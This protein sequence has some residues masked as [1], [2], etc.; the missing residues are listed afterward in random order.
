[1]L[2][3]V[4]WRARSATRLLISRRIAGNIRS[5]GMVAISLGRG[6]S[7]NSHPVCLR[8]QRKRSIMSRHH[9]LFAGDLLP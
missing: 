9:K 8:T 2:D 3:A 5:T 7:K 1:M 6:H 4:V